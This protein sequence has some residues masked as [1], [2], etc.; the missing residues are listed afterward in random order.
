MSSTDTDNTIIIDGVP[1]TF[2]FNKT[3]NIA[4]P[5]VTLEAHYKQNGDMERL[6]WL[7]YNFGHMEKYNDLYVELYGIHLDLSLNLDNIVSGEDNLGEDNL[8]EDNLGE[9]NPDVDDEEICDRG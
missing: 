9:D 6:L 5:M 2:W 8:G 4:I 1:F 7:Y 3:P